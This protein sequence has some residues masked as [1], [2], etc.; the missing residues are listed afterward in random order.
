MQIE[1]PQWRQGTHIFWRYF[2]VFI[3]EIIVHTTVDQ[4]QE[5]TNIL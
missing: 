1:L 3:K 4:K 2:E 5:K